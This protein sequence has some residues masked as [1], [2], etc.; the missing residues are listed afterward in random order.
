MPIEQSPA[1]AGRPRDPGV[2]HS[3]LTATQELLVDRG[4]AGTT[5]AAVASRA[6]CGKSAIYRRWTTKPELVVA[7]VRATQHAQETPDTGN[8]RED[9][10]G[11]AL[12]F[13]DSGDRSG[14]VLASVLSE[15]GRDPQLFEA[16]YRVI[17][18]PPVDALIA[19]IE[20]WQAKGAISPEVHVRLIADIVP[21]AAFGSVTL[22]KRGLDRDTVAE[23]VDHVVLPALGVPAQRA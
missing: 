4:Y 12:H 6:R 3:I 1:P 16:A 21:T 11:A 15:I 7:A 8:L 13:A 20:R 22:R 9:L 23:L 17:G 19:V 14:L 2:E 5:I 10:L 18:G